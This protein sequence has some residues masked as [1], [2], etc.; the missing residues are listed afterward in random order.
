MY[1]TGTLTKFRTH[2]AQSPKS[3]VIPKRSEGPASNA[4]ALTIAFELA[5]VSLSFRRGSLFA[6]SLAVE[7]FRGSGGNTLIAS[8]HSAF[9]LHPEERRDEGSLPHFAL[10]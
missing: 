8:R 6:R 7:I 10:L 3:A 9:G 2:A 1:Y 5:S 4:L